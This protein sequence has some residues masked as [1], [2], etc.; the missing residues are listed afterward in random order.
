MK[1]SVHKTIM[2]KPRLFSVNRY[3]SGRLIHIGVWKWVV[4]T[5]LRNDWVSDMTNGRMT[6][7]DLPK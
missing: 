5:D 6:K 7:K 2:S 1:I 3:W 4:I